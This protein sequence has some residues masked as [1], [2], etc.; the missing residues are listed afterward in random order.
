MKFPPMLFAL[1]LIFPAGLSAQTVISIDL[2]NNVFLGSSDVAGVVPVAN[3][4]VESG[5]PD[6][7]PNGNLVDQNGDV[8][9]G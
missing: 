2:G 4:Q 1:A 3:W 6:F 7:G 9:R 5:F 8:V